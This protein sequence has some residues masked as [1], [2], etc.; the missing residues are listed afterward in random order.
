MAGSSNFSLLQSIQTGL[1]VSAASSSSGAGGLVPETK[2][3]GASVI[4]RLR[5][6]AVCSFLYVFMAYTRT[7]VPL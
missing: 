5:V 4:Q 1:G 2:Q 6:N 3:A 7:T